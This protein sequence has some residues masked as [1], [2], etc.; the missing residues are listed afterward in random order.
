MAHII[1]YIF[2]THP[3]IHVGITIHMTWAVLNFLIHDRINFLQLF[4][5][6]VNTYEASSIYCFTY[7]IP[8]VYKFCY[9]PVSNVTS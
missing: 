6:K 1:Y 3:N 4:I 2:G 8:I 5:I 7:V 9:T